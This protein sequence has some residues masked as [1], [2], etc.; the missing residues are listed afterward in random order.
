MIYNKMYTLFTSS[1]SV[2]EVSC[3]VSWSSNDVW[4]FN[5]LGSFVYF[6]DNW[7]T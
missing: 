3:T 4:L 6:Y 7:N 2:L 1:I 5:Y